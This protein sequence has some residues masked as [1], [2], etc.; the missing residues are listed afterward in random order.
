MQSKV[1]KLRKKCSI[2]QVAIAKE[3]DIALKT[4]WRKEKGITEFTESEIKR[5][6]ELLNA[7]FNELF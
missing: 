5:L 6:M 1:I 2:S 3:L 7:D 4:Y